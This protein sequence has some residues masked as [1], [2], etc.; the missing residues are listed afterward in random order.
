M[1]GSSCAQIIIPSD[2]D[3]RETPLH[4]AA[5]ALATIQFE[6]QPSLRLSGSIR[7]NPRIREGDGWGRN[8]ESGAMAAGRDRVALED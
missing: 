1:A 3:Q 5:V 7:I 8:R 4:D 2:A 6:P